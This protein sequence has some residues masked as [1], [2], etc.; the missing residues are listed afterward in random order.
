[1]IIRIKPA[2]FYIQRWDIITS[3][4]LTV[5]SIF[6]MKASYTAQH[7]NATKLIAGACEALMSTNFQLQQLDKVDSCK[8]ILQTIA[9]TKKT[10]Q[11]YRTYIQHLAVTISKNLFIVQHRITLLKVFS[12]VRRLWTQHKILK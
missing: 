3:K 10:I 11:Y 12:C 5:H 2:F 4:S 1:M 9:D 8:N 6:F 7:A